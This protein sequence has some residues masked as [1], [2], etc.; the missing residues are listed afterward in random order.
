MIIGVLYICL[1]LTI[2]T[3]SLVLDPISRDI[4]DAHE[5]DDVTLIWRL[6]PRSDIIPTYNRTVSFTKNT[7]II[8]TWNLKYIHWT[9]SVDRMTYYNPAADQHGFKLHGLL[10]DDMGHYACVYQDEF[11]TLV[12]SANIALG[13]EGICFCSAMH[14]HKSM[15]ADV[16]LFILTEK[17]KQVMSDKLICT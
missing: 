6:Y 11:G 4:T 10:Q 7:E 13:L 15:F 12:T 8:A 1:I 14:V 16:T 3:I 5:N 9:S 17:V 2:F